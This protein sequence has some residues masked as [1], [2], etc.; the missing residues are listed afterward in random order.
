MGLGFPVWNFW[1]MVGCRYNISHV[2]IFQRLNFATHVHLWSEQPTLPFDRICFVVLVMR[3]GGE[4]SW[5]GPWHLV[6]TLEVFHV[7]TQ[8]PGPVHT[9]RLSRVYFRVFSLNLWFVCSFVFL[10]FVCVSPSFYVSLSSWVISLTVFGV[11]VTNLN[12]PPRALL[13][14]YTVRSSDRTVGPTQ[15]TSDCLSDHSDRPVGQTVAESPTSVNQI[16][17]AC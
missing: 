14:V 5:S 12:E 1:Y 13:G 17:V 6:C 8:L 10:W 15:A 4:S 2:I 11:S 9:D 7:R 16:N 3:K